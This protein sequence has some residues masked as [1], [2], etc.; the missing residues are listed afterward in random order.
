MGQQATGIV[1][2]DFFA[3]DTIWLRRL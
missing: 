1:A 3:V 2:C